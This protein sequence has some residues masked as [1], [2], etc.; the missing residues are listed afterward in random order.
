MNALA[1]IVEGTVDN[2][3]VI[4][5]G[6]GAEYAA[7][8]GLTGTWVLCVEG[9]VGPGFLYDDV[10]GQFLPPWPPIEDEEEPA[11]EA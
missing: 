6:V 8:L 7:T 9:E 2:V 4:P 10:S 3:I 11:P 1:H 5:V